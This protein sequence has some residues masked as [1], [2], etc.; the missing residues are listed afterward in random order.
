MQE[1]IVRGVTVLAHKSLQRHSGGSL[2][3]REP[4]SLSQQSPALQV[5]TYV[6]F[7]ISQEASE[8]SWE[9]SF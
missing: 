5:L 9:T 6:M 1:L 2:P 8:P 4:D 7:P 3:L